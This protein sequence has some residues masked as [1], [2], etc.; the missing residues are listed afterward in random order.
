MAKTALYSGWR[1]PSPLCKDR[2]GLSG[3]IWERMPARFHL[4]AWRFIYDEPTLV[5]GGLGG[6][7]PLLGGLEQ[8]W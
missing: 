8:S 6:L 7:P 5:F 3:E 2:A 4:Y 1:K